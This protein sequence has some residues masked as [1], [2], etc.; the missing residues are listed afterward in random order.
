MARYFVTL[1]DT[2]YMRVEV[3]ADSPEAA[4]QAA[5]ADPFGFREVD[6][7]NNGE[8][9]ATRVQEADGQLRMYVP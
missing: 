9:A 4:A 2:E 8:W 3:E 6:T 7:W 5:V 1:A